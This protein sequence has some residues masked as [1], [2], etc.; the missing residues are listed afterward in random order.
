M[1]NDSNSDNLFT[2]IAKAIGSSIGSAANRASEV[3]RTATSVNLGKTKS[4]SKKK[5]PTKKGTAA[6]KKS[7]GAKKAGK[8]LQP[9]RRNHPHGRRLGKRRVQKEDGALNALD[10]LRGNQARDSEPK[11]FGSS[12]RIELR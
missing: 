3:L 5:A 11:Q 1:P 8:R 7:S 2:D 6:K 12:S 9:A 10:L 4:S